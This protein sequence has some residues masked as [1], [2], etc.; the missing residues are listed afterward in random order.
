MSQIHAKA[1]KH[2]VQL[3]LLSGPLIE[4]LCLLANDANRG[5]HAGVLVHGLCRWR[6]HVSGWLARRSLVEQ[7]HDGVDGANDVLDA[8]TMLIERFIR[9]L[10]AGKSRGHHGLR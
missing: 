9:V 4:W 6:P 3:L 10:E 5:G 1:P 7:R 8:T 2:V